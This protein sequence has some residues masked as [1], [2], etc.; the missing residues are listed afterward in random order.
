VDTVEKNSNSIFSSQHLYL[1]AFLI[2][3]GHG[4]TRII[5]NERRVSFEFSQ[6]PE[7]LTYRRLQVGGADSCPAIQFRAVES[8]RQ[9]NHMVAGC[10]RGYDAG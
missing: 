3:A 10:G 4:V 6:T 5:H 9:S 7:L 8:K 2:C 1:V